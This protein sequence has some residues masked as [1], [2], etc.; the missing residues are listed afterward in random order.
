MG[1]KK[2]AIKLTTFTVILLFVFVTT[3]SLYASGSAYDWAN[4]WLNFVL[5]LPLCLLL[6]YIDYRVIAYRQK[7]KARY[8]IGK[9]LA[10]DFVLTTLIVVTLSA[11]ARITLMHETDFFLQ[12]LPGVLLNCLIVLF[13]ELFLYHKRQTENEIRLNVAKKEKAV[14]QFEALKNQINPHFL[15]NSL[16]ALS[17]LAYQ[18][19]EKTN[20]LAKKLANVYRY[21]LATHDRSSVTL[22]EELQF[23]GSYLFLE[24][25]RFG[26]TLQVSIDNDGNH[27]QKHIIPASLQMLVENAIKHNISTTHSPLNICITIGESGVTVCNNLQLRTHVIRNGIGLNNLKKQYALHGLEVNIQKSDTTFIVKLPFIAP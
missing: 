16:N 13:V 19:A 1:N 15:F 10:I 11:V 3:F 22:E 23:L 8:N 12:L 9:S 17:S 18:D 14:Y 25:I 20:L 4:V 24:Q 27:Q 6:G 5:N 7:R 26:E 2:D 21:L